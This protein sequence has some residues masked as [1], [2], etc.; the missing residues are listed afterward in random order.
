MED[1]EEDDDTALKRL[2]QEAETRLRP[3]P[4]AQVVETAVRVSDNLDR[5]DSRLYEI[6]SGDRGV[7]GQGAVWGTVILTDAENGER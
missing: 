3:N 7:G 6:E 5:A 1:I 4:H 2:M